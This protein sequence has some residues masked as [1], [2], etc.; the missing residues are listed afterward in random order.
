[1]HDRYGREIEYIRI[2]L[3]EACN[4]HCRY[5]RP[6]AGGASGSGQMTT[7]EVLRLCR[8]FAAIGVRKVKL[9]GGEPLLRKD[10]CQLIAAI[11]QIEGVEQ[12]TL[13]TN[14]VLLGPQIDALLAA[15]ID[16]INI[17]L[18]TL[19]ALQYKRLTGFDGLPV[20]LD[21]LHRLLR[22][23]FSNIKINSVL[24]PAKMRTRQLPWQGWPKNGRLLCGILSLCR[25]GMLPLTVE[26]GRPGWQGV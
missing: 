13:T 24:W 9:T 22:T 7:A 25:W 21:G 14:G 16:G 8:I 4:L 5:C 26:S 18:D 20:V 10:L 1:M 12:V 3:T 6:S 11:K 19:D 23:G 15:G 2:S 17:S